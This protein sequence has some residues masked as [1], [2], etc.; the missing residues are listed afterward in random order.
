MAHYDTHVVDNQPPPLE[1]Y[2]V[3]ESDTPLQEAMQREGAEWAIDAARTLGATIGSREVIDHARLANLHPPVFHSHDRFGHRIDAIEFHPS[4]HALMR[5]GIESGL[6]ALPWTRKHAHAGRAALYYL[7]NQGENG[8]ACPI[9]MTFAV[10]PALRHSPELAQVWEPRVLS[11]TYDERFAPAESKRNALMGMAM[12]EKQGGSDVRANTT[13]AESI[14]NDEY[15]LTGHKWFCSSPHADAFLTLAQT[16][17]GLTCFLVPRFTPD[18]VQ[19]RFFIQRLKNKL[20]NKSNPSSEIEYDRTWA[21]RVG[22]PGRGVPTIINMVHHT[23]LDCVLGSA[24]M[25]RHALAHALHHAKHRRAFGKRLIEQPLMKNVLADLCLEVEGAVAIMMRLAR[26]FD[27]S[28]DAER[29]HALSRVLAPIAKYWVCKRNTPMVYEALECH[30]GNGYVED[31][32]LARLF[33]DAPL[34]SIW[35]GSGN[36]ICLDVLRALR[37]TPESG[38]A[39]VE[40]LREA[41]GAD[42]RY[43]AFVGELTT[44]LLRPEESGA[45]RIVEGLAVAIQAALLLQHA[46]SRVADAF[47]AGR[48]RPEGGSSFG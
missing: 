18:G 31:A 1:D 44:E 33:R 48:L 40:F 2:N 45:R 9:T 47:V 43:D 41:K 12:T 11:T 8:C 23:R 38:D 36:V 5:L 26:A 46:P 22:E 27:A 21:K 7:F 6:S 15:I 19:N 24:G 4:W 42:R 17:E 20:G 10:V 3:F 29:E 39:M 14:G 25:M 30:G 32:P 35:E 28:P 34:N 37:R 13:R 16:D